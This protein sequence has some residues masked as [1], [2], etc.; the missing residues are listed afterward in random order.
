MSNLTPEQHQELFAVLQARFEKNKHR[1]Q[2]LQWSKV[3]T[4]LEADPQK[5]WSLYEMEKT[6]GEP[7]VIGFDHKTGE[8]IFCD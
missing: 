8:Y 4:K 7:D 6:G 2:R 3:Q 1:H 5:L